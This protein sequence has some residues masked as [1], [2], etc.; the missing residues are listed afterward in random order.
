MR[1]IST[2]KRVRIAL[3]RC[4]RK[5]KSLPPEFPVVIKF[6]AV[7]IVRQFYPGMTDEEIRALWQ[8][9]D[10]INHRNKEV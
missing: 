7:K 10:E 1:Y 8:V 9:L 3:H 2:E 6:D 5:R 4:I